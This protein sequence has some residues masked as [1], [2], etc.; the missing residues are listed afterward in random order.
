MVL[1][2]AVA[3]FLQPAVGMVVKLYVTV[4]AHHPGINASDPLT[5]FVVWGYERR[6]ITSSAWAANARRSAKS[7]LNTAPPRL[8]HGNDNG[9]DR[10]PPAGW[11]P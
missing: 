11:R 7:Q 5:G 6:T 10:G 3:I 2:T 9:V 8:G 4:P 1:G